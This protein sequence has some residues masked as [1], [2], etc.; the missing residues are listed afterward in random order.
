[1]WL[2][3][4]L[5]QIFYITIGDDILREIFKWL[6]KSSKEMFKWIGEAIKRLIVKPLIA[7]EDFNI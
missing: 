1:M 7:E 6:A 3:E 4:L 2:Q 5:N